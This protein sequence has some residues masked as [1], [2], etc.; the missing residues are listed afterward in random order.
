MVSPLMCPVGLAG[1][2]LPGVEPSLG[3]EDGTDLDTDDRH[4]SQ[5]RRDAPRLEAFAPASQSRSSL[6][7]TVRGCVPTQIR[8]EMERET[9]FEPA[10]SSLEG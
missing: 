2:Y 7:C 5:N 1:D 8:E 6:D 3:P 4:L 10:T 9:G